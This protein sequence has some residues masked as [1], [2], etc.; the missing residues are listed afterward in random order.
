[1]QGV[2]IA[3]TLTVENTHTHHLLGHTRR[4]L[5][6]KIQITVRQIRPQGIALRLC[7]GKFRT[8]V[9]HKGITTRHTCRQQKDTTSLMQGAHR[10]QGLAIGGV[11]CDF[12]ITGHAV[13]VGHQKTDALCKF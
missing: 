1:M 8:L 2:K 12:I 3:G 6:T 4:A 10:E 13:T 9:A 5:H 11:Y 7:L